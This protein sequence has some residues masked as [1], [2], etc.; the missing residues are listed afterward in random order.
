MLRRMLLCGLVAGSLGLPSAAWAVKMNGNADAAPPPSNR[1]IQP[2][3]LEQPGNASH[4]AGH[5]SEAGGH[6]T[7]PG[8]APIDSESRG[9]INDVVPGNGTDDTLQSKNPKPVR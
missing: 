6:V 1:T 4:G 3:L 2:Q 5:F 8:T 9:P 7:G